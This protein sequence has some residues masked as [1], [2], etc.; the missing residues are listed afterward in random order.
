[1]GGAIRK[2]REK[3]APLAEVKDDLP[4]FLQRA[5]CACGGLRAGRGGKLENV[6]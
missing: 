5:E 3:Q 6:K 4:R 1:M 2:S